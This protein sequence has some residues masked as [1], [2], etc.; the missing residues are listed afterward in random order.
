M[1]EYNFIVNNLLFYIVVYLCV[2]RIKFIF[3]FA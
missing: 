2:D 1:Y 3:L